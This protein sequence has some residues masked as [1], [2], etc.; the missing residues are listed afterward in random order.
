MPRRKQKGQQKERI[1]ECS[2]ICY[3]HIGMA[4]CARVYKFTGFIVGAEF[5]HYVAGV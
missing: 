4:G 1:P 3:E 5:E 2:M